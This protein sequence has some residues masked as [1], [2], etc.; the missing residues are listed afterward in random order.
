MHPVIQ[1]AAKLAFE[2]TNPTMALVKARLEKSLPMIEVI[3]ELKRY[4]AAPAQYQEQLKQE[5]MT[6]K[7][8]LVVDESEELSLQQQ[9]NLLK[10]EVSVLSLE[11]KKLKENK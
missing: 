4:K 7:I 3:T 6:T 11:I 5:P 10:Q 8:E 9:L 2:G 1:I